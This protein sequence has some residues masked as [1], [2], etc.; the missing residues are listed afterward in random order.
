MEFNLLLVW[1][2]IVTLILGPIWFQIRKNEQDIDS[3][4]AEIYSGQVEV[5]KI[6]VTKKDMAEDVGRILDQLS[7][8]SSSINRLDAKFDSLLLDK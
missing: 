7:A 3:N 1:N 8:M 6:Y 4:K 2:L 5:A